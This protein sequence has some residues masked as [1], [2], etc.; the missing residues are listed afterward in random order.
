MD[1][2]Y[3][4]HYLGDRMNNFIVGLTN[5]PPYLKPPTTYGYTF[6]G[7][8]PGVAPEGRVLNVRCEDDLAPARYV[9]IMTHQKYLTI[10]EL[11]VYGAGIEA[12]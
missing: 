3:Y 12:S 10:C 4:L 5:N 6:C 8:W 9:V 1:Y 11:S 7:Q 2:L